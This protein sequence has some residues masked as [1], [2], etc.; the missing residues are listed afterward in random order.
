[1]V[2]RELYME[3]FRRLINKDIVK[4]LVGIRR[5]GKSYMLNLLV[6]ELKNNFSV[7][8]EN[9]VLINFESSKYRSI[10]NNID[11]ENYVNRISQDLEGKI[12]LLFDEIQEIES[13]EKSI[14]SF[15]IDYDCDIYITG[16]NSKLLSG[17]LATYLTGRY[18]E[19]KIYPFSFMEFFE[20]KLDTS[21]EKFIDKDALFNDYLNHGGMPFT[22][23]LDEEED[24]YQ[25]LLDTYNSILY[26]DLLKRYPINNPDL[27][28][29]LLEYIMSNVGNI[30]SANNITN[31]L[32]HEKITTSNKT[33]SNYLR[34]L[35][36]SSLI[37]KV[38]QENIKTKKLLSVNEKYYITDQGF[39]KAI[40]GINDKNY[41]HILEN[42]VFM[43]LLR[44]GYDV[45]VGRSNTNEVDFVARKNQT[46]IYVQVSYYMN[47]K[48]TIE[49]EFKLLENIKDNYPK[50]I[51]T[52]DKIDYSRNG[53]KH[54]NIIDF[55]LSLLKISHDE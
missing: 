17:E 14:N 1:M 55:L 18:I 24:V 40:M 9:I 23:Q 28:E 16:S 33:I 35:E 44:C 5:C 11:L 51:V 6:N 2:Q 32:K 30:L 54:F 42:I 45:Y 37:H 3:K 20:Y 15:L 31:Y 22:L 39:I 46:Q 4:V 13:W 7:P 53:I 50:Y 34:Y 12:Y 49:R 43:E 8:K 25:Y 29:R 38:R 48:E 19:I 52:M 47:T 41:G 10:R 21:D 36:N 26:K 27:I